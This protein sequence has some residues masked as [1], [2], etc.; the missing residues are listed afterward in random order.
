MPTNHSISAVLRLAQSRSDLLNAMQENSHSQSSDTQAPP[1]ELGLL[2][3]LRLLNTQ[4][5][6]HF[7][8][9]AVKQLWAKNPWHILGQSAVEAASIMLTPVA[10]RSPVKLVVGAFVLGGLLFITRPWRLVA[11]NGFIAGLLGR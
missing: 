2:A 1:P 11:K 10:Q 9:Q 5:G 3:G 8:A 4:H 7:L 6:A